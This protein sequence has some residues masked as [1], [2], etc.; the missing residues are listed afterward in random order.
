MNINKFL[1]IRTHGFF[2][3][4]A[5][6]PKVEL[7]SPMKNVYAHLEMLKKVYDKGA[8]LA[9]FPELSITGYSGQDLFLQQ[10]LQDEAVRALDAF[11]QQ[12]NHM[13]MVIVVGLPLQVDDKL[14]N[15]AAILLKGDVLAIIPKT[16]LPNYREFRET[17]WFAAARH[18]SATEIELF[19]K[20]VPFGSDV[21]VKAADIV[22]FVLH[23]DICEDIW[24]PVSPG[25]VAALNGATVLANISG[26]N[27]TLEK[28]TYR[29]SLVVGSSAKNLA[30]QIYTS[31]GF[32]E[33]STDLSWDG[34]GMIVD[35]G[36]MIGET[37]RFSKEGSF[38]ICDIDLLTLKLDRQR[39]NS[40]RDNAA[41]Y[42]K[43]FRSVE[44][45]GSLGKEGHVYT[46]LL[47]KVDRQPFV[48]N[49]LKERSRKSKDIINMQ[50]T[51]LARRITMLPTNARRI[52]I[53]VSGGLDST[54]ALLI[55]VNTVD[56]LGMDRKNVIALTMPGF[57]TTDR[58]KNNASRLANALG[59]TLKTVPIKDVSA[60]LLKKVGHAKGQ[61]DTT[62]ENVQAW[63]RKFVELATAAEE[64]GLVLGTSDLSELWLGWTTMY[65]DHASH[66]GINSGVPK[67]LISYL[68]SWAKD[69][70][71]GEEPDVQKTL[72]DILNTPVSPELLSKNSNGGISQKTEEIIGPYELHDFFGYYLV[73]F[74]IPPIKIARL[75]IEAFEGK[76][77]LLEI[78]KW[79]TVFVERFFANQYKR[80]VLPDGPKVGSVS[81]SP[82]DDWKMP[83]DVRD[84]QVWLNSIKEIP[85]RI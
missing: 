71:F 3:A 78:K 51:S 11:R 58:T 63:S 73:R 34:H 59:V 42:K 32:G 46:K 37:M 67:T 10:G 48:P 80:S 84:P 9:V 24:V 35:R 5:L 69:E 53:G 83:S 8:Q 2:R 16:Y 13:D 49:D 41:D 30:A 26:S 76:Y 68:I 33:S 64:G 56:L 57:G 66:Y 62:F 7:A 52:I 81:P 25:T 77:T 39:M 55:A 74:G 28:D 36:A 31:S 65:G 6:S 14:F 19:G 29:R 23:V 12:T 21:L 15:C 79:L 22:G 60:D 20:K 4:A 40:F 85:E 17:R 50:T 1:D 18:S 72:E 47:R 61:E 70:L 45:K 44:F 27:A 75:A 43:G 38:I 54:H 82:R